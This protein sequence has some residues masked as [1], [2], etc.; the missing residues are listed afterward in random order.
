MY[1]ALSITSVN[2]SIQHENEQDDDDD[3]ML[4]VQSTT[5]FDW[6]VY[7]L[8]GCVYDLW[9]LRCVA[10]E[11]ARKGRRE[12]EK[13]FSYSSFSS[14]SVRWMKDTDGEL[15][16]PCVHDDDFDQFLI[17]FDGFLVL[18]AQIQPDAEPSSRRT[19]ESFLEKQ[20]I[21]RSHFSSVG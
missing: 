15:L 10:E 20:A 21:K 12:G 13:D 11:I 2:V 1:D 19:P 5:Y 6:Y 7:F 18:Y 8:V 9:A 17:C 3:D 16:G 14:E 4:V